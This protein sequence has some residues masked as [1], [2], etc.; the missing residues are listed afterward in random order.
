M[1]DYGSSTDLGYLITAVSSDVSANLKS[2]ALEVSTTWVNS[3]LPAAISGTVPDA[4]EKAATY[5]AY[6][7]I[8]KNLYDTT[9]EESPMMD[10]YEKQANELLGSYV[11]SQATED[12]TMHPYSG[13][14]SPTNVFT[15]RNKRTVEDDTDYDNVDDTSWD[16]E[17]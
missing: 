1:A 4:V 2:Y 6:V 8:L 15:Q 12:S 10:W 16:S 13:N 7:F 3:K 5:Y 11:E 14:L 9:G 17:G